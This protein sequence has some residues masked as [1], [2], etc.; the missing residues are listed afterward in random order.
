MLYKLLLSMLIMPTS[1]YSME[2]VE[3]I[4]DT[5]RGWFSWP[6]QEYTTEHGISPDT[7][8]DL[9]NLRGAITVTCWNNPRVMIRA[10]KHAPNEAALEKTTIV[11]K[12]TQENGLPALKITTKSA[13]NKSS[14][15]FDIIV[16]KNAPLR[17][18]SEQK[19]DIKIKDSTGN[20]VATTHE[21]SIKL[22]RTTGSIHAQTYAGSIIVKLKSFLDTSS[23]LLKTHNGN[24][25]VKVDPLIN[26]Y[27]DAKTGNGSVRSDVPLT[28]DPITIALTKDAKKQFF[29]QIR[30]T[31]GN[32]VAPITLEATKGDITIEKY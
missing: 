9:T 10:L 29:K 21:G 3:K 23:L 5:V 32:G 14:I 24:I 26:A 1:L 16:P 8:I 30:G 28:L 17:I 6:T 18:I 31:F 25:T 19:G 4:T 12:S 27:L 22:N 13:D 2:Y 7:I 11:T 15:D 20:I